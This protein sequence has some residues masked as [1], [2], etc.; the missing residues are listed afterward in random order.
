[1]IRSSGLFGRGWSSQYGQHIAEIDDS[2][3]RLTLTDGKAVYFGRKEVTDPFTIV[4]KNFYGDLVKNADDTY[5]LTY[6]SGRVHQFNAGGKPTSL[7]DENDN[8]TTL[9]MTNP[10]I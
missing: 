7:I 4:S 1:M 2:L 8:T 6:E 3:V 5:T 10:V 9:P